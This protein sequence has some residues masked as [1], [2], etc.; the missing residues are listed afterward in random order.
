VIS[1]FNQQQE[2]YAERLLAQGGKKAVEKAI[3]TLSKR[4]AEHEAK[5]GGLKYPGSVERE[6]S[7]FVRTIQALTNVLK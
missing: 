7:G 5:V 6:I 2:A 4:L 1:P 3:K